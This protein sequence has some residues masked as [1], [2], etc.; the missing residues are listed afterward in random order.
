MRVRDNTCNILGAHAPAHS[1]TQSVNW[2][3][4]HDP[5]N[6]NNISIHC[7]VCMVLD[8]TVW[9]C[10][11]ESKWWGKIRHNVETSAYTFS[12]PCLG[13]VAFLFDSVLKPSTWAPSTQN[14]HIRNGSWYTCSV[15][16]LH[17]YTNLYFIFY[18]KCGDYDSDTFCHVAVMN[19][20]S[21]YNDAD[22][23]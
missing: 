8:N 4:Q 7:T 1:H 10:A 9:Q 12:F 23:S 20:I 16:H 5:K 3:M 15:L 19:T 22:K 2:A 14:A 18:T 13:S 21:W 11:T 6:N 17:S